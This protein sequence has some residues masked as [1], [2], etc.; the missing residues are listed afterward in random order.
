[1]EETRW[2]VEL[3]RA[4]GN[5][6]THAH[7]VGHEAVDRWR[8]RVSDPHGATGEAE[9][10]PSPAIGWIWPQSGTGPA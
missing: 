4:E 8:T 7:V 1:L 10:S 3:Q 2:V 9:R 5:H 6:H